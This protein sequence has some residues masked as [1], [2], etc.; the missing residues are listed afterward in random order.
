[1]KKNQTEYHIVKQ[2]SKTEISKVFL[3]TKDNTK[4]SYSLTQIDL[5]KLT[6]KQ[7]NVIANQYLLHSLLNNKFVVKL[8]DTFQVKS[9]YN[10]ITDYC[11]GG[12]LADFIIKEKKKGIKFIKEDVVWRLFIQITLGLYHIHLKKIVHRNLKP[13]N[14]LL[15]QDLTAKITNFEF[16]EELT[17]NHKFLTDF[18]GTPYYIAP[19]IY[20]EKPY[21]GK[22]DTWALGVIL[23]ELCTFNKPFS[24][25]KAEGLRSKIIK[26]EFK[27]ITNAYSKEMK[28]MIELLLMKDELRRPTT[29]EIIKTYVFVSKSK[30]ANLYD[31]VLKI[32]PWITKMK[33]GK[34][35]DSHKKNPLKNSLNNKSI[36]SNVDTLPKEINKKKIEH[37]IQNSRLKCTQFF[38]ELKNVLPDTNF[39]KASAGNQ[40]EMKDNDILIHKMLDDPDNNI[41]EDLKFVTSNLDGTK[42]FV[43]VIE[44]KKDNELDFQ[45]KEVE[46]FPT[47]EN[48]E[49]YHSN[50]LDELNEKIIFISKEIIKD[51]GELKFIEIIAKINEKSIDLDNNEEI[52]KEVNIKFKNYVHYQ[53]EIEKIENVLKKMI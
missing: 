10:I 49:S 26:G 11:E 35:P 45:V 32:C 53:N 1:M 7:I 40:E 36:Q 5:S 51:I 30:T 39:I 43:P 34:F 41:T 33:G 38:N 13:S 15:T 37:L 22:I 21:N 31:F 16:S 29:K 4:L 24:D 8:Y 14:I 6:R 42:T 27:P 3:A 17:K 12:T 19:E 25:T 50:L 9:I 47:Q 28:S 18:V 46:D 20:E 23:Y 48:V 2:I 52:P 44:D